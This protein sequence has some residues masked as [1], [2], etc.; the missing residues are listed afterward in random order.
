MKKI[1]L[2]FVLLL[3]S[4][5][6]CQSKF[7]IYFKDK[8]IKPN[9]SFA[10]STAL[11][12]EALSL[13]SQKSIQRRE[14]VMGPN[15]I[16]YEDIPLDVNYVSAVENLGIRIQNK[17]RWFNAVSAY[18]N[19]SQK[20]EIEKL[21]FVKS[22]EPVRIIKFRHSEDLKP[23]FSKSGGNISD[24]EY[25]PSFTQDNLSNIPPVHAKGITGKGVVI[26]ILDSGF[27]WKT[28][29]SLSS[30]N[31][32]AEYDFVQH[33][34]VTA[35]QPGDVAGQDSHG[36]FV[37]SV[38]GGYKLNSIIGPAY[39]ASYILA[40]TENT[41]SE[42]HIEE[43]NYAAAL[44]WME[45]LGVDITTSS[46]GYNIFDDSTY[47][48]TYSQMD[49]N[50]TIVTKAA[51]LAFQRGV[52]TINAAGNEGDNSWQHIIAPADAFNI[53]AV[54][55]VNSSN[56]RA[57][58]SS[59]GP[60]ADGRIKPDITA[61]G[62][63]DYGAAAGTP[64]GYYHGDGTSFATPIASGVAA[65]LKSAYPQLTNVQMRNI[66]LSTSQNSANPN[67]EIGYGLVSATNAISFPVFD[68]TAT[69]MELNKIFFEP[70]SIDPSSVMI[71]FTTDNSTYTSSSVDFDGSL[72][73]KF[74][75]P[76]IS[77][78]TKIRFYY[79]LKDSS[80]NDYRF[81]T[82]DNYSFSYGNFNVVTS[83]QTPSV[84]IDYTLSQNYPNPFNSGTTIKFYSPV[85]QNANLV[86]IN[87]IG[88]KIRTLF[89]GQSKADENF[90][91]WDGKS[92]QGKVCASGV[93]FYILKMGGK[94]YG[95]KMIFLK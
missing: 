9:Q 69:G 44:Q 43:D 14:K 25:G 45:A 2:I 7:M 5:N 8:G 67:N 64:N 81:P 10:K 90:V 75:F 29:E 58:F 83:V 11:Y 32:I 18:L 92:D 36:T 24:A 70:A 79:T 65:L 61:Q 59:I 23:A 78:G 35:N 15:I 57:G 55:A 48:Y 53:I 6:F 46:L 31:V 68:S 86:V 77:T 40:K 42:S 17:L 73:Y 62:V 95:N 76:S 12:K 52:L 20:S 91:Y 34:S 72:K 71:H 87:S 4:S 37:F 56:V 93:Y 1:I 13:L 3:S 33:D 47:S 80:N 74:V 28:H 89:N 85:V 22:I 26:G 19:D 94:E 82:S 51:N 84:P 30:K 27:R 54:G 63:Y 50:T 38:I 88:Q 66:I 41:A 16:R 60:T 39:N 21:N 49:G